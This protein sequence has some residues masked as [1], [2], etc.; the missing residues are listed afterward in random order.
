MQETFTRE[1]SDLSLPRQRGAM[2]RGKAEYFY[3]AGLEG[4][5]KNIVHLI[6]AKRHLRRCEAG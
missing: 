5:S 3:A 4:I 2:A 1:L 6:E